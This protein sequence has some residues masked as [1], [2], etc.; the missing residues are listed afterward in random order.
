M[1]IFYSVAQ[2]QSN[3]Q[4]RIINNKNIGIPYST[5][6]VISITDSSVRQNKISDSS[7]TANF[8]LVKGQHYVV[9]ASAVNYSDI[10]RSIVVSSDNP[11]FKFVAKAR[12]NSLSTVVVTANRP[13]MRQDDDKTIVDPENL[14][15]SSTNAYEI[16]EKVPGL[17]VDQ[18]GNVYLNS[19]TP[20]KIY[21]NGRE[22]KLSAADIATI[23][24]NLPPN[25][26]SSI[27]ILQT[28]SAKYDASGTGGI[29]NIVLKKGIKIG[30]T[31]SING[32]LNQGVYG[33]QFLGVTINNNNGNTSS[34]INLQFSHRNTYDEIKTDRLFTSDSLLSQDALTKYPAYSYY[35]G[36][37]INYQ[38]NKEWEVSYDGRFS[39][40]K[41][42]NRSTN[43]STIKDITFFS[44]LSINEADVHNNG[45]N[46][47]VSQGFNLKDKLDTLG[48][49]WS[50]DLSFTYSPN[51]TNQNFI[52]YFYKPTYPGTSGYGIL[53]NNPFFFSGQTNLTKKLGIS[54]TVET[55]IKSSYQH[56]SNT[57]D[58]Y[59]YSGTSSIKDNERTGAYKYT[60]LINSA[61]LQ[62]SKNFSGIILKTGVRMENTNMQG[63]QLS[64]KDTSFSIHRTDFFPYIYLSRSIMKIAGY[65]LKAYLV[66][67]R[68]ITRPVYDYL[69]PSVRFIDPYLFEAGNPSLHPQFTKNY[70]A[71][72][73][74]NDRPIIA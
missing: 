31:G 36:Y 19:T 6:T 7:G 4:I 30:L 33:N 2:A 49:E 68:T 69:N 47:S 54:S 73:S 56:F 67:R 43:L 58:Y 12:D 52:T 22:Q 13:L 18:D 64:P 21:I 17:Y 35:A 27:E 9:K 63:T 42:N 44:T 23:L 53:K 24:K 72:V 46:Y 50:T 39:Y 25:A 16:I 32:G 28:P 38:F 34:Y 3:V 59:I 40:S 62:A 1:V 8:Q 15:A 66:Y 48:S 60:E 11:E 65:D 55:G 29:V 10:E 37:G 70:E 51:N 26:I 5:I 14:V 61:Y 45:D 71:N 41:S 20:A 74:V 57:T